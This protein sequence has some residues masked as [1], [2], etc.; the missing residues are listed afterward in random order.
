MD[1]TY[2]VEDRALAGTI[3]V[4]AVQ[5]G[6]HGKITAFTASIHAGRTCAL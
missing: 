3:A 2:T 5:G 6:F 4:E 1:L